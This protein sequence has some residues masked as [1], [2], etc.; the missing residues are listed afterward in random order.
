MELDRLVY[1]GGV[2]RVRPDLRRTYHVFCNAS[3]Q[4][5]FFLSGILKTQT[6]F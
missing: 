4:T 3:R 5:P 6:A 1:G 2:L